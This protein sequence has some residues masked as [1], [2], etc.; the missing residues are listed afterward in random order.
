M[1]NSRRILAAVIILLALAWLLKRTADGGFSARQTPSAAEAFIASGARRLAVP[2]AAMEMPNP[3]PF[4]DD[5]LIEARRHFADH[6]AS[7]H[8]NNG[9][10]DT[11]M[12][13]NLYPKAPDMRLP[14][15]QNLTDGEIYFVI[16]NG[17]RLSGMPAWG[18]DTDDD[19]E[20]WALVHFIR[21][22]PKL[23]PGEAE[24]MQSYN[25]K[26]PA[27]MREEQEEED[28]LNGK[29]DGAIKESNHHH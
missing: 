3:V 29:A 13:R 9:S 2:R 28:F 25:P 1:K 20:S 17:I 22:L 18:K 27:E 4:S 23:S 6:C 10:G 12:G 24:D 16:R 15:T 7:C 19:R 11:D 14:A 5:I 8:A 26:S 21:H